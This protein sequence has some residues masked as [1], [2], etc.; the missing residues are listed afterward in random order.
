M[1]TETFAYLTRE[2]SSRQQCF[3]IIHQL[4]ATIAE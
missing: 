2:H 4:K 1:S 3:P